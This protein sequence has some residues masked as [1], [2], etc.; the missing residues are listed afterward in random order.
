[1]SDGH[2]VELSWN[3]RRLHWRVERSRTGRLYEKVNGR[4][5]L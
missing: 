5:I 2:V 3:A 1:M 4:F